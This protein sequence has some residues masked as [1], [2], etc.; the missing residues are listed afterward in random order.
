MILRDDAI[1]NNEH[2][3]YPQMEHKRSA[4]FVLRAS[5]SFALNRCIISSMFANSGPGSTRTD[6]G[7]YVLKSMLLSGARPLRELL[8]AIV[9]F[10]ALAKSAA[11]PRRTEVL[12]N[13]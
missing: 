12:V 5:T 8:D 4:C 11:I 2:A 13:F 10:T 3:G 9:S 1:K 7:V 6:V